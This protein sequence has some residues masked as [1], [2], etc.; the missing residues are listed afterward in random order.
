MLTFSCTVGEPIIKVYV[1]DEQS[2]AQEGDLLKVSLT[3]DGE[4]IA[5]SEKALANE[6]SGGKDVEGRL[7][8]NAVLKKILTAKGQLEI[9]VDGHTQRYDME[10]SAKPVAA[11]LDACS[12]SQS[13]SSG[14]RS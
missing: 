6:D 5:F 4:R 9:I 1:Q 10:G 11:L 14:V 3:A 7:P 13:Q 2:Q 8:L 12:P